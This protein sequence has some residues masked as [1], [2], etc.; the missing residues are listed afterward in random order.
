M[1]R[2]IDK[3]TEDRAAEHSPRRESSPAGPRLM[4]AVIVL[5]RTVPMLRATADRALWA[6]VGQRTLPER[7]FDDLKAQLE[8][9]CAYSKDLENSRRLASWSG[10]RAFGRGWRR[11]DWAMVMAF[12]TRIAPSLCCADEASAM[13]SDRPP[14]TMLSLAL[15]VSLLPRGA[16]RRML[17]VRR[18]T[19]SRRT[20]SAR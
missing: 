8:Q 2:Q 14:L 17:G 20:G 16:V 11:S 19:V 5:Q 6:S 4:P 9:L 3:L 18:C 13:L 10:R 15:L 1:A 7:A 12:Q